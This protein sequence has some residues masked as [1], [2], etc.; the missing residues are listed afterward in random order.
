M[1]FQVTHVIVH[2]PEQAREIVAEALKIADETDHPVIPPRAVFEEACKLL[3]QR[4]TFAAQ[5]QAI[6]LDPALM[7]RAARH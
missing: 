7:A 6:P 5:P 3:G 1:N 2:T 4:W